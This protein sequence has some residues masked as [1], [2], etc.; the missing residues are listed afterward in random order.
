MISLRKVLASALG[1]LSFKLGEKH[2]IFTGSMVKTKA[3][4]CVYRVFGTP[5]SGSNWTERYYT[6]Q[7]Y[8]SGYREAIADAERLV[9]A[10]GGSKV[11]L[12]R[13]RKLGEL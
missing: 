11:L 9:R 8:I 10:H 7:G 5:F 6:E 4:N 12:E 13:L 3:M 1:E 2:P